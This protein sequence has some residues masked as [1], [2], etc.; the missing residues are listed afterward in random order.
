MADHLLVQHMLERSLALSAGVHA[1]DADLDTSGG[2]I[3]GHVA[4]KRAR[5]VAFVLGISPC[6]SID[7][8][9]GVEAPTDAENIHG[10]REVDEK[11]PPPI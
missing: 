7:N 6:T 11:A 9:H 10:A 2:D 1:N 8:D 3:V 4:L 5:G